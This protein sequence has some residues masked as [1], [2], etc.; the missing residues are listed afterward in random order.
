MR[1]SLLSVAL[2][3][4]FACG[5]NGNHGVD[6]CSTTIPVP[7]A[8]MTSCN[9][10]PGSPNTC[11]EGFHCDPDGKCNAECLQGSAGSAQC[12]AG[13]TCSSD[14]NCVGSNQC[15]GIACQVAACDQ[16]SQSPT[17]ITG[18]VYAPNGTL[19]LYGVDVYVPN[20]P[21]GAF[22]SGVQCTRCADGLPGD[23]IVQTT[24]DEAG[25]F[26]LTGVPSGTS[27]PVVITIGKW[28]RQITVPMIA[29]CTSTALGSADTTLPK[30]A[31]DMTP[32]T[33][34]VD[35]PLIAITTGDADTLECL[36]RRLGVADKEIGTNAGTGHVHLYTG[37]GV[38]SF[39]AG[40]A[41]GTGAI[42]SATPFWSSQAN[43]NNYDIVI[44]SCEGEQNSNTKPQA[45]M[46]AMKGYADI[47]GR[48]FMSHW[49][50]IWIEGATTPAGP[51]KPAVWPTIA[52]WSNGGDLDDP[53]T[54]LID[55]TANPKGSSFATWML[56]VGGSTVRDQITVNNGRTTVT[57]VDPTKA[58]RWTYVQNQGMGPQNFQF[59][60]PVEGTAD[61]ACGK[62]VFSD[63]HV[64]GN[65]NGSVYPT[66]CG[67]DN[68][69]SPQEKALAFMLFDI[70][71]CVGAIF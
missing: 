39:A 57:A 41:G 35:M 50:N 40:Y 25:N 65:A 15:N 42:P 58:Q 70:S 27:I 32:N 68:T 24:T 55:E 66:D 51:Q 21:P 28:R 46:D 31:D 63:M 48:I 45:A 22:G 71:S 69:L 16:P 43:L 18:T 54:D 1:G 36:V 9:A 52:T 17:T 13:F 61:E 56:N 8:C 7:A 10:Q 64:S 29:D 49:H 33:T 3:S 20:D 12:G 19:P 38:S 67:T 30:S 53:S 34:S 47:G 37:N 44:L 14:G 2:V 60:T 26:T 23:P 11:P 6:V 62:V 5:G 4:L 59:V